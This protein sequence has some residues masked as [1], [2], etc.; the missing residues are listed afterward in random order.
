MN[1]VADEGTG[2]LLDGS[3]VPSSPAT[4]LRRE[5]S[6]VDC[7]LHAEGAGLLSEAVA[8]LR[9]KGPRRIGVSEGSRHDVFCVNRSLAILH[10]Q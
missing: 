10:A 8:D 7:V 9:F 2:T 4:L 6:G 3:V 1:A 5:T